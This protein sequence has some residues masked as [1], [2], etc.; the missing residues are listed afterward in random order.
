MW[1]LGSLRLREPAPMTPRKEH[2]EST[3]ERTPEREGAR[4]IPGVYVAAFKP[5]AR[6]AI[7]PEGLMRSQPALPFYRRRNA[8]AEA[9]RYQAHESIFSSV[10]LFRLH[11]PR[12]IELVARYPKN[13][14]PTQEPP[15]AN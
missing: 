11:F 5:F 6:W 1:A 12:K 14:R 13:P 3:G 9:R 10:L 8:E 15:H 7:L 2:M 4:A